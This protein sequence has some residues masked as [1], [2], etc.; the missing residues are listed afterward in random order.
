MP[1]TNARRDGQR[2]LLRYRRPYA[3][4]S[5]GFVLRDLQ[6]DR[7]CRP[8][9][10]VARLGERH[11]QDLGQAFGV[12]LRW[13]IERPAEAF[14]QVFG[15]DYV[16][17]VLASLAEGMAGGGVRR[18]PVMELAVNSRS[19]RRKGN[20]RHVCHRPRSMAT[21]LPPGPFFLAALIAPPESTI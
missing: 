3:A 14:R 7:L 5:L 15:C 21:C 11:P 19:S 6:A 18:R 2:R 20:P 1:F 10:L 12:V 9:R 16:W 4:A 13:D 8:D 17:H